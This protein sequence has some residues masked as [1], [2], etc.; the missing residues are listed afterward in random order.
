LIV[1]FRKN[2]K[3]E[4]NEEIVQPLAIS[5]WVVILINKNKVINIIILLLKILFLVII[6]LGILFPLKFENI[7]F[8]IF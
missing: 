4:I 1:N 7:F 8:I 5:N 2:I 6:N 3:E